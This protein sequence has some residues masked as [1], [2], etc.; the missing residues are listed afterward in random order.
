M[1]EH[2]ELRAA[3]KGFVDREILPHVADW[4]R[5]ERIP[6]RE[7]FRKAGQAGLLESQA[8]A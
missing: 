4:E 3:V 5:D 7:L 1:I 2:A 6:G 8:V